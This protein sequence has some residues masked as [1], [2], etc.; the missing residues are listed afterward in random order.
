M[1]YRKVVRISEGRN[2]HVVIFQEGRMVAIFCPKTKAEIP[3]QPELP[4]PPPRRPAPKRPAFTRRQGQ[5][6]S[7]IHLYTSLNR[8]PPAEADIASH[9]LIIPP[10]AHGIVVTLTKKGLIQRQPGQARFIRLR[11]D[12][13]QLPQL[14]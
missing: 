11:I 6:L 10:S 5:V 1:S 7:F 12:P 14:D 9:F 13:T 4:D 2:L 3:V 8:Q